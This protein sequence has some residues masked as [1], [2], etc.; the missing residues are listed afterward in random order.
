MAGHRAASWLWLLGAPLLAYFLH[1]SLTSKTAIAPLSSAWIANEVDFVANLKNRLLGTLN[2]D[3]L[4]NHIQSELK[5]L[6]QDVLTDRWKYTLFDGPLSPLALS[7]DEEDLHITSSVLYSG[8]TDESGVTGHLVNVVTPSLT[9]SPDWEAARGAIAV[10]NVTDSAFSFASYISVWPGSPEWDFVARLPELT[11]LNIILPQ[12]LGAAEAGVKA[13]IYIWE[14]APRELV[15]GQYLP[16]FNLFEGVPAVLVQDLESAQ[17]LLDAAA[18]GASATVTLRA[19]TVPMQEART[20]YTIFE[21]TELRNESMILS[22][23][24]DGFNAV[25]ENGH[26]ALLAHARH[27][28]SNPPRRTTVLVFI[29]GHLLFPAFAPPPFRATSRWLSDHPELWAGQG[30]PN[31]FALGGQLKG[32]VSTSV[33][34]LGAVHFE[35]DVAADTYVRTNTTEPELLGVSTLEL[36]DLL[37]ENWVGA[38]PN[39]TRVSNPNSAVFP[40][41]GEGYPYFLVGI[42]NVFIVTLPD[43]LLK[44]WP[45]NFDERQ[46]IDLGA[47][48]RQVVSFLRVWKAMDG[49]PASAFGIPPTDGRQTPIQVTN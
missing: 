23:H 28:A 10:T 49:L 48:E 5:N 38:N 27:L 30:T 18:R 21:G 11:A 12:L 16:Y 32:V 33:E 34:H 7:V 4:I 46:L 2:H 14:E 1:I 13:V 43:Y 40:V 44:I 8:I 45:A 19:R 26:I 20:L 15:D 31:S 42:P 22:T 47:L 35:G 41:P 17:T 3:K 39:V 37:R 29:G 6:G 25:E 9:A 36:S 24:T